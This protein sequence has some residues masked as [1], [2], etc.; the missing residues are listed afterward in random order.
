MAY[1]SKEVMVETIME[2]YNLGWKY[3]D[4]KELYIELDDLNRDGCKGLENESI[5][6]L[7]GEYD[8]AKEFLEEYGE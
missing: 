6:F 7:Q 1:P 8:N 2:Y 5:D 4:F 3:G